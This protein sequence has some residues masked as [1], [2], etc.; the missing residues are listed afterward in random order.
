MKKNGICS[1]SVRDYQTLIIVLFILLSCINTNAQQSLNLDFEEISAKS[2]TQPWGWEY[3]MYSTNGEVSLDSTTA[4]HGRQ[5]L[6]MK[7]KPGSPASETQS[8]VFYL[9][10]L[11]LKSKTLKIEGWVRSKDFDGSIAIKLQQGIEAII[12]SDSAQPHLNGTHNWQKFSFTGKMVSNS[13]WIRISIDHSGTGHVWIDDMTL[14][15]NNKKIIALPVANPFTPSQLQWLQNASSS[16]IGVDA[17]IPGTTPLYDDLKKLKEIAADATIIA[18]GEATHGTSEFF[19]MKNRV[20]E[21]AVKEMG[22]RIFGI[23]DHQMV[24]EKVNKYVLTGEGNASKSMYGMFGVWDNQEVYNMIK[25]V[26]DYNTRYPDDKVEFVGFDMQAVAQP[27]DSLYSF[28][29][30]TDTAV[31]WAVNKLLAGLKKNWPTIYSATDSAKHQ[32][33]TDAEHALNI[34]LS[35]KQQWLY[36]AHNK[37]DT[38]H[39]EWGVQYARLVKQ[40]ARENIDPMVLYRDEAMAENISWTLSLR[41]PKTKMLIWAHDVHISR[42]EHPDTNLNYHRAISM[43]SWLAKKYGAQYKAF[44]LSTYTGAYRSYP[45]YTDYSK[46]IS[47]PV[48]PGPVGS[49]DEALHQIA[50]KRKAPALLLDLT[51]ARQQKWISS[52]LPVRFA[53]HV[54]YEYA[55]WTRFSVP[56]QFDGIIFIDKTTP[57]KKIIEE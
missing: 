23:E 37:K 1:L 25:W 45:G 20:L 5:S 6:V 36:A 10:P 27:L 9:E 29:Q 22:V 53:N 26:R 41:P 38:L 30:A 31:F 14:Y 7:N 49:L 15:V 28:L 40:F 35:K 4:H 12:K 52:P 16:L 55:Y 56:Y 11:L 57:A 54:C 2:S 44:G 32:W 46:W 13:N 18:L 51:K 3:D 19:R 8:L 21:Y 33:S 17:S 47:C 24:V 39:I 43:G 48:Y 42:G 50:K 34:I